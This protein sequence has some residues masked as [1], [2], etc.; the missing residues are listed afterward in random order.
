MCCC[1]LELFVWMGDLFCCGSFSLCV[2]LWLKKKK[3]TFFH[4]LS[5]SLLSWF[6]ER[7]G[8]ALG[9]GGHRH[10][11]ERRRP[12]PA[13]F[14]FPSAV[15]PAGS[16]PAG[17]GT[18]RGR[19]EPGAARSRRRPLRL[20]SS[21]SARPRAPFAAGR[22]GHSA[23]A[24]RLHA[25]LREEMKGRKVEEF[26][27]RHWSGGKEKPRV[28]SPVLRPDQRRAEPGRGWG[29]FIAHK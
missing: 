29:A 5:F 28:R 17:G 20:P 19:G 27:V 13:S 7:H 18:A 14:V 12:V 3:S 16:R 8:L 6:P 21:C 1:C 25:W 10:P 2:C 23:S 15:C 24:P 4:S 26:S 9:G 11:G 22:R